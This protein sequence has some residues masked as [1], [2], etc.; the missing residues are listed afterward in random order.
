MDMTSHDLQRVMRE[1]LGVQADATKLDEDRAVLHA[2]TE[3][4]LDTDMN[5]A[6]RTHALFQVFKAEDLLDYAESD[7]VNPGQWDRIGPD[8]QTHQIRL[9]EKATKLN[10][11]ISTPEGRAALEEVQ[12]GL[13]KFGLL[14]TFTVVS[15]TTD[16]QSTVQEDLIDVLKTSVDNLV[17]AGEALMKTRGWTPA[18]HTEMLYAE[19]EAA[20]A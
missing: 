16:A 14:N 19:I 9:M 20:H 8:Q 10:A 7:A 13:K 11:A 1:W 15:P 4:G 17:H 2:L 12:Q 5:D 6:Q 18:P 3:M